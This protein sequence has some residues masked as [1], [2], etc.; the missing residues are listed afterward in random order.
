MKLINKQGSWLVGYQESMAYMPS[1]FIFHVKENAGKPLEK[2][3]KIIFLR[4]FRNII[5]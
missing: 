1:Y 5:Q 3:S 2:Q 4:S